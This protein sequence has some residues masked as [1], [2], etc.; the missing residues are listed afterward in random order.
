[1][2]YIKEVYFQD[3]T[4]PKE[5]ATELSE[6]IM[7]NRLRI[8][9]SCYSRANLDFQTMKL[10]KRAGCHI[11]EVGLESCNDEILKGI[12]KGI[13]VSGAEEFVRNARSNLS[14]V[15]SINF[16]RNCALTSL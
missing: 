8:R 7:E 14:G 13:T 11:L 3:D 5:R 4:L 6:V 1:M 9:W 15:I 12:K 10:M 16:S 2:P